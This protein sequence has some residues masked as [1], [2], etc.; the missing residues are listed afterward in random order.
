MPAGQVDLAR[1]ALAEQCGIVRFHHFADELMAG[2]SGEPVVTALQFEIGVAD[3]G[4]KGANQGIPGRTLRFRD[5]AHGDASFLQ[6]DGEH[7]LL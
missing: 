6:V 2:R 5:V 3:A 4:D 1:D 7:D